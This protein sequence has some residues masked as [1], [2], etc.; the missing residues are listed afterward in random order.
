M[1]IFK[2]TAAA[3]SMVSLIGSA[4]PVF[5]AS[6]P[7]DAVQPIAAEVLPTAQETQAE[8]ARVATRLHRAAWA[9]VSTSAANRDYVA[10]WRDYDEGWYGNALTEARA[11]DAALKLDPNWLGAT[12]R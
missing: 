4:A 8:L 12:S 6:V 11:A 9:S 7:N 2:S 1:N 3:L 5:A 10:A